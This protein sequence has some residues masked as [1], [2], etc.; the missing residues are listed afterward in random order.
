VLGIFNR[1]LGID[2]YSTTQ[3]D[4]PIDPSVF[5]PTATASP[6]QQ[7]FLH[8]LTVV[9]GSGNLV[10]ENGAPVGSL[11]PSSYS[12]GGVY[13][14][15]SPLP[16]GKFLASFA[17]TSDP[18]N[19]DAS[20][21]ALFVMDPIAGTKTQ[22][23]GGGVVDA[24]A[25]Y[26][27]YNHGTFRSAVDEPNGNTRIDP[28]PTKVDAQVFVLDMGI[29]GSLLFQN[30]PTG[31]AVEGVDQNGNDVG[32]DSFEVW[33]ELPP[34]PGVTD[35]GSG[36]SNVASDNFGQVYVRRRMLG[37]VNLESDKS[38]YFSIPGGVPIVLHLPDTTV[39][40]QAGYPRWQ[41]EEMSFYPGER[42]H[43]SFPATFFN[44]LCA[45]CHGAV[46]G[47]PV[48]AAINPDLLTQ[49][50]GVLAEGKTG[51]NNLDIGPSQR[52]QTTSGPPAGN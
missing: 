16:N 8:S 31:R 42:S 30:T 23:V 45:L 41:K 6:E 5:D 40:Q 28:D 43:Q 36:G 9:D 7:F 47:L 4:Y 10:S 33:E 25:V 3:T 17:A 14:S 48:D 50:S 2:F 34:A 51:D 20:T 38:T 37:T 12:Q 11:N 29:L 26:G 19:F 27:K 24:V 46:S 15:P 22:L 44:G 21:Y 18:T 49:A 52:D 39:S 13:R 32:L 1:S 35:F